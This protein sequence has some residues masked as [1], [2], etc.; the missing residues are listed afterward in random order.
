MGAKLQRALTKGDINTEKLETVHV[1][2]EQLLSYNTQNYVLKD[3]NENLLQII[4]NI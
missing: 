3:I 2:I 1:V 4:A